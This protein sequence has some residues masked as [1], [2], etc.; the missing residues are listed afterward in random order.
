MQT[1]NQL[2][3]LRALDKREALDR[4]Q[5]QELYQLELGQIGED[6]IMKWIHEYGELHWTV[7]QNVWLSHYGTFE[8]DIILFTAH[9]MY[10]FEIKNYSKQF[11][12]RNGQCFLGGE[13]IG[14]NPSSQ[15]QKV[16]VNFQQL[17]SN[18]FHQVP[19]ETA[20]IFAGEHCEVRI[21]DEIQDVKILQLNQVRD[22]VW[23]IA[24]DER[25]YYGDPIDVGRVQLILE[26][27]KGKNYYLPKPISPEMAARIRKGV[28]CSHCGNFDIDATKAIITC[29]RCGMNEPRENAIV[30][31]IC[32]YGVIHFDKDLETSRIVEF[33]NDQVSRNN[34]YYYLDK[35]FEQI[36]KSRTIL[37]KNIV[38]PFSDS[39]KDFSFVKKRTLLVLDY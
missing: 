16:F 8:C 14:H 18:S 31:T 9:K 30:R 32:E 4:N 38:R 23:K 39:Y 29:A 7:M 2:D 27:N 15:A 22:Y 6:R 10:L 28:M 1:I 25:L 34:I 36:G 37:F 26:K 20:V 17:L 35:H 19:I 11:E 5:K 13:K 33:F 21:H 24:A 12:L 3:I